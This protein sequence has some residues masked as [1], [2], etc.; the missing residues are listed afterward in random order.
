MRAVGSHYQIPHSKENEAC[1]A[2][3]A[4]GCTH[5]EMTEA[6]QTVGAQWCA[7]S[8]VSD[9]SNSYYPMQSGG[10]G[11]CG[12]PSPGVR[13]CGSSSNRDVCCID[14]TTQV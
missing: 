12:G 3:G 6:Q 14:K 7:C 11:G 9:S 13:N 5:A 1:A 4:Q 2:F 8:H 10:S